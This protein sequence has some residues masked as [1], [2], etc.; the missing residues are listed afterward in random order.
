MDGKRIVVTGASCTSEIGLAICKE[1]AEDGAHLILVARSEDNL[2]ETQK[3]LSN[4]AQHHVRPF[5]L[6]D[7]DA[8]PKFIKELAQDYGSLS[9]LVHSASFQGYSPVKII[10]SGLFDKYFH[11]NAA[12][13][14]MLAKGARQKSV[15]EAEAGIVFIGSASGA[16][17][18]KARSLYAASK[19]A[20]NSITKSLALE[21]A[22]N[23][24]RVNTIAPA[25][26]LGHRAEEQF[27]LLSD[28]QNI[29]LEQAHPYGYGQPI[30]IAKACKFLLSHEAK[31]ITGSIMP[32]DGGFAAQ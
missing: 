19:A 11:L 1:L 28:E 18:V 14:L 9:G 31:W 25:V 12:V 27:K 16:R 2:R 22:I 29:Q 10:K 21:L 13:P 26:V 6:Y 17:G 30:D 7:L 24:I 15:F 3:Q 4:T 32:V 23:K 8:I 20:L 5:D